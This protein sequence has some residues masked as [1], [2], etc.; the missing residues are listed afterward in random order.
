MPGRR[1]LVIANETCASAGVV[2]EVRYRAASR[3]GTDAP[4]AEVMVVAPALAASRLQHW[5]SS[6]I[7][8]AQ[9]RAEQRLSA[10]LAA[11]TAAGLSARGQ[12]GDGDPLQALDDALRLYGP[13]EVI[14]S[15]HPPSRSNWLERRVV[16][17]ARAQYPLPITHVVVDVELERTRAD[18]DGRASAAA[19]AASASGSSAARR[20]RV[21]HQAS[22]ERALAIRERGFRDEPGGPGEGG[23]AGVWVSDRPLEPAEGAHDAVLFAIELPEGSAGLQERPG[24]DDGAGGDDGGGDGDGDGEPR[25]FLVPAELL[26]RHGPP[27]AMDDWSE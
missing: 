17:R 27:V 18:H 15:T 22:Y 16:E 14:I 20:V 10:S 12:L 21:Y 4:P 25:R 23:R 24:G 19:S 6:D 11:L 26:N 3:G 7:E 5:L 8:E 13:D 1:I 2:E 9:A